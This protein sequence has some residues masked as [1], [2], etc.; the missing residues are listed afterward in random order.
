MI[1]L[2][3]FM[4]PIMI[5]LRLTGEGEVFYKQPRIGY[6]NQVFLIWKFATM[7]KNSPNMG[8]GEITLRHDP[9]VTPMG[10]FLRMSKINELPQLINIFKG[11]MSFVGPRPLMKVSFDKYIAQVQAVIYNNRPGLTGIGSAIFRDEELLVSKSSLPSAEYYDKILI[12]SKGKLELWYQDHVSFITDFKILVLTAFSV[13][14]PDNSL[15]DKFF[16]SIPKFEL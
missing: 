12:P 14:K 3:P 16:P 8:T 4:I 15:A 1:I 9:R 2:A 13:V 10:G 5:L 6:K 7:L 11:D